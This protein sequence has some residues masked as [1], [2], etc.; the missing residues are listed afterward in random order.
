MRSQKIPLGKICY[1]TRDDIQLRTYV[2]LTRDRKSWNNF[3]KGANE[4][5]INPRSYEEFL[6]LY[7][8]IRVNGINEPIRVQKIGD[9]YYIE[10]GAHRVA[11]ARALGHPIIEA[12][13]VSDC[14]MPS[15]FLSS[16][17]STVI[18]VTENNPR[19]L[20]IFK[21]LSPEVI[22]KIS[23]LNIASDSTPIPM[24][25]TAILWPTSKHVWD[26][27]LDDIKKFHTVDS[28]R[29]MKVSSFEH[30]R[31]LT[32]DLYKSDDVAQW[33]VEA[34]FPYFMSRETVEYLAIYFTI[35]DARHRIKNK[36]GNEISMAIEDLKSYI[37]KKYRGKIHDYP[38]S[39]QPDLLIHAGDNEY[40]T[41]EIRNTVQEFF[42]KN[43]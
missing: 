37:R 8:D 34:K 33:K 2:L 30:M 14:G 5:G 22:R 24:Q 4:H 16:I 11:A 18:P 6:D 26:E 41:S 43:K 19:I 32:V 31:D 38:T 35:D 36:T 10:D 21:Y 20:T 25:G 15:V 7:Q 29:I 27:I 28:T 9:F 40:Q 3:I 17:R 13:V 42:E 23:S 39:G 12:F 1:Q